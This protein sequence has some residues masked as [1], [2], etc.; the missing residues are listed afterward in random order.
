MVQNTNIL[1]TRP[2]G[3]AAELCAAVV[4]KGFTAHSL[5]MLQVFPLAELT[6]QQCAQVQDLD[7][8]HHRQTLAHIYLQALLTVQYQNYLLQNTWQT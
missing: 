4:A 2:A 6:P 8:Y 5:P 1:V 7:H 3:Q